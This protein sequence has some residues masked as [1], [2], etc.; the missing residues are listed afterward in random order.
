LAVARRRGLTQHR[1]VTGSEAPQRL[2]IPAK[3]NL[4]A[5]AILACALV[6]H[7][8][9][10]WA[11]DPD[12][13]HGFLMPVVCVALLYM[14]RNPGPGDTLA[15][16]K[17]A[18]LA[19]IMGSASVA[20]LLV[21]GLLAV[22]VDWSSPVVDF[23][24]ASSFALL[25]CGAIAAFADS[26]VARVRFNWTSLAAAALWPLCSPLPPGTYTRLTLGLQLWVSDGVMRAL[27]ILGVAAHQQ[28][29]IIELGRGTVGIEEACSGVR[30]LVSCVFAGV[31]FSA[32]LVRRPWA[33]FAVI[34]LSA[35]LA[36]VMNFIRSLL[37]T[38]LVN[39]GVRIEGAWHDATGYSVLVLTAAILF[40]TAVALDRG[41]PERT[42]VEPGPRGPRASRFP[43][44]QAA[45]GVCLS[46]GAALLV[47]F[48]AKMSPEPP[49]GAAVPD[50]LKI[51][52][53]SAPGW[54]VRT[55]PDLYRFAGMLRTDHLEQR[56]YFRDDEHGLEQV[57]LYI[58][59]WAGGQ[60]SVGAV[61]SHTPDACWPG[62]GWVPREV[63]DPRV[64]LDIGGARLPPAQHRFFAGEAISQQVWFWQVYG[65]RVI[66]IGNTR[67]VPDLIRI[68]LRFGFRR[69]G[70]QAF[71][72]VS[73]NRPWAEI[74][75]EPFMA[76]F[77]S[78]A[79][80]LGLY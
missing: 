53:A 50:L 71:I 20:G 79:R 41:G 80:K 73:S 68:A 58:A 65:G 3:V 34:V 45:L 28:G 11:G 77:F 72:R 74:S 27:G 19:G 30:S 31:L 39:A 37:L 64:E 46:L 69:G 15:P 70:D 21:A 33:R 17:A 44:S 22:T 60:A 29:N 8:W 13:S 49:T 42:P 63:S 24:L 14:S 35:P 12:L 26:Q 57:T 23:A 43:A 25:G 32:A 54:T 59:Y 48:A 6:A 36:L 16:G 7:L 52:P 2:P 61:G 4:A 9:P 18:L 38:L 10:E 76:E 56:S 1:P 5:L 62:A 40:G 55:A 51:L 67:S 47:F 75:R 78:R 66:E